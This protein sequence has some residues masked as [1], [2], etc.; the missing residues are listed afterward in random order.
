M[1]AP[2]TPPGA[3]LEPGQHLQARPHALDDEGAGLA[4][5]PAGPLHVRGALPGEQVDAAV[6]HV[7]HHAAAGGARA[8]WARTLNV[9]SAS[10]QRVAPACPAYGACGGCP[11]QHLDYPGAARV[12][13]RAGASGAGP[14][15]RAG[16]GRRAPLPALAA[17]ARLPEPGQVRLRPAGGQRPAGAGGLCPALALRWST[18]PAAGWSSRSSIRWPRVLRDLLD[19]RGVSPYDEQQAHRPPAL[20]GAAD[21]RRAGRCWW[22]WSAPGRCPG[23]RRWPASCVPPVRRWPGWC[24]A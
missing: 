19:R 8:A 5:V 20:C 24:R 12:E 23:A 16:G 11:L 7:S 21:Q 22:R 13:D 2:G 10:P 6:E 3:R 17:G 14:G 18:C 15:S 9:V 4:D 1:T